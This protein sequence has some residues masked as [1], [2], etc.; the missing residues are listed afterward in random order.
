MVN[1]LVTDWLRSGYLVEE[2]R[3]DDNAAERTYVVAVLRISPVERTTGKKRARMCQK[4]LASNDFPGHADRGNT[5]DHAGPRASPV[6]V[7]SPLGENYRGGTG[8]E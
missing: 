7:L 8:E 6:V 3:R 2:T 5:M 4:R 1:G